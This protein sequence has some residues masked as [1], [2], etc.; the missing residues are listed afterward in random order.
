[1]NN[2]C[3]FTICS[4]NYL[5]QALTLRDS[6]IQHE[7]ELDFVIF[8]ADRVTEEIS[9]VDLEPLDV[10][11]IPKWKEMALKYNVI[12]FNTSIKPF[13]F[14]K[15]FRQGYQKVVYLD[16]DMYVT[17]K[18]DYIWDNLDQYSIIL[19]PHM[20]DIDLGEEGVLP[21]TDLL[22]CGIYN[23]GFAAISN[24]KVGGIIVDW[25]CRK[26]E[27]DCY[28]SPIEG[29]FVDQKWMTFIP[30]YFPKETL[31]STHAGINIGYW[32]LHE[33]ELIQKDNKY[34]IKDKVS[35]K[36]YPLLVYHFSGFKPSQDK[37]ISAHQPQF[38]IELYPSFKPIIKEYKELEMQ[39]G[40]ERFS[41]MHYSFNEFSDGTAISGYHRRLYR[42]CLKEYEGQDPFSIEGG[43]YQNLKKSKL[44]SDKKNQAIKVYGGRD[45]NQS[46]RTKF[47][48]LFEKVARPFKSLIG[49]ERYFSILEHGRTLFSLENQTFLMQDMQKVDK[50]E[51]YTERIKRE[52]GE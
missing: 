30:G 35:G 52:H 18:L 26:L 4:K 12:E 48:L 31:V 38:N 5:A 47:M 50:N 33:R 1:M 51:F 37:M 46:R 20:L 22:T 42:A 21:E 24:T 40:Y 16:P 32:N 36:E 27:K 25:W 3:I 11:W 13:C 45:M 34:F 44:V 2:I 19:T 49:A 39:N 17:D 10:T 43:F 6:V 15:L 9:D 7:P 29:L 8:L 23:L 28:N 14:K 41:K